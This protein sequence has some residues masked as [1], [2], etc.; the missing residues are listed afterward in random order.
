MISSLQVNIQH[1]RG[2]G[3]IRVT[4]SISLVILISMYFTYLKQVKLKM[5]NLFVLLKLLYCQ[6]CYILQSNFRQMSVM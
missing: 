5:F 4:I 2:K 1:Q 6:H 3:Q